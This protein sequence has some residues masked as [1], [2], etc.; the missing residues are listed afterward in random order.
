MKF[1]RPSDVYLCFNAAVFMHVWF[2]VEVVLKSQHLRLTCYTDSRLQTSVLLWSQ[3]FRPREA[4]WS[5]LELDLQITV[6]WVS[7][8]NS[9][10]PHCWTLN[11]WESSVSLW[12]LNCWMMMLTMLFVFVRLTLGC[13]R[14]H[15]H[16]FMTVDC[17]I[18]KLKIL[19]FLIACIWWN[20]ISFKLMRQNQTW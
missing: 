20:N 2:L 11:C 14:T 18:E 10:L 1:W 8:R 17:E 4:V 19:A 13:A 5:H 12:L 9:F 15:I 3:W 16:R 7:R 6:I